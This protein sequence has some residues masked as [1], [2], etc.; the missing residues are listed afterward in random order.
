MP[1]NNKRKKDIIDIFKKD[2]Y[3]S[4]VVSIHNGSEKLRPFH[5]EIMKGDIELEKRKVENI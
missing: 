2:R 4:P 3:V 5:V 1:K